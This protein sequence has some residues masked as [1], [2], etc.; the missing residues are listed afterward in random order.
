[1]LEIHPSDLGKSATIFVLPG[2]SGF[3][4]RYWLVHQNSQHNA[5][6]GNA[7]HE[8]HDA[9]SD[10]R[11]HRRRSAIA[12]IGRGIDWNSPTEHQNA[13]ADDRQI[14]DRVS[15]YS[16]HMVILSPESWLGS[17]LAAAKQVSQRRQAETNS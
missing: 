1:M 5:H 13:K 16:G 14:P 17:N 4:E 3:L 9:D 6:Q 8:K 10:I 15:S 12:G 7:S 2:E 11:H